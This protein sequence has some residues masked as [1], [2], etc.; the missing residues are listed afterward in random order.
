MR[1]QCLKEEGGVLASFRRDQKDNRLAF[2][3]T[4]SAPIL[5]DTGSEVNI[6]SHKTIKEIIASGGRCERVEARTKLNYSDGSS[7]LLDERVVLTFA[8]SSTLFI[9]GL[10]AVVCDKRGDE[11]VIGLD[12]LKAYA[13]EY[14]QDTICL[15]RSCPDGF[16]WEIP[17]TKVEGGMYG[18]S[19]AVN[20]R[21]HLFHFDTGHWDDLSLPT[22][23]LK[24]A[25]SP[26]ER[27]EDT[28]FVG[29]L[30]RPVV[31][32]FESRGEVLLAGGTMHGRI[33]YNDYLAPSYRYTMNPCS[34]FRHFIIDLK[35]E[36]MMVERR[37]RPERPEGQAC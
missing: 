3:D 31:N 14:T 12:L 35:N 7:D 1:V 10:P 22:E 16:D 32:Y 30:S 15:R 9:D 25:I 37:S 2:S 36:V 26:I 13:I 27:V 19:L 18:I 34:F 6:I 17:I 8:L 20:G 33:N 28:L 23:D 11:L 4:I 5:F 21:E 24:Y 29:S